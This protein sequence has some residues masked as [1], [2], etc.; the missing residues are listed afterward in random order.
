MSKQ[1][2]EE[3]QARLKY[4]TGLD[5]HVESTGRFLIA[6]VTAEQ[7]FALQKAGLPT[8][9]GDQGASVLAQTLGLV[10][11]SLRAMGAPE[12]QVSLPVSKHQLDKFE[13]RKQCWS[14]V[15]GGKL[16][17]AEAELQAALAKK[18]HHPEAAVL[19]YNPL[20]LTGYTADSGFPVDVCASDG[21]YKFAPEVQQAL[22]D[23]GK[24]LRGEVEAYNND[25]ENAGRKIDIRGLGLDLNKDGTISDE[26][27]GA[28]LAAASMNNKTT[29]MDGNKGR[30]PI[31][32]RSALAEGQKLHMHGPL[33]AKQKEIAKKIMADNFPEQMPPDAARDKQ[34][35]LEQIGKDA[36]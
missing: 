4:I 28:G 29:W 16:D 24:S 21:N 7:Y 31:H 26:E 34:Q 1:T 6:P 11:G 8:V 18:E 14:L 22:R 36:V 30:E 15:L 10:G 32:T 35:F 5:F 23:A 9:G 27:L 13:E 20:A 2:P 3:T 33:T 12:I 17:K 19:R 25:P